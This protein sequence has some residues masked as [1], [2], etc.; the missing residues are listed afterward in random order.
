MAVLDSAFLFPINP[1]PRLYGA[2][3]AAIPGRTS[4]TNECGRS[5]LDEHSLPFTALQG[6]SQCSG[7]A[8][9][10]S[11]CCWTIF[12][13][14]IWLK[15]WHTV[16][17]LKSCSCT[18]MCSCSAMNAYLVALK[19]VPISKQNQNGLIMNSTRGIC[20]ADSRKAMWDAF[21]QPRH[22]E[23]SSFIP[24]SGQDWSVLY[25]KLKNSISDGLTRN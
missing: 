10:N 19:K 17:L 22:P 7:G 15:T 13:L 25:R 3:V 23:T 14:P 18:T 24:S 5:S 11:H 6:F 21:P 1:S 8:F 16:P 2:L 20:K 9:H 12:I 4:L